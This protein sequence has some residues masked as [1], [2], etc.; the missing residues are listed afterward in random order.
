VVTPERLAAASAGADAGALE[1]PVEELM[2][3]RITVPADAPL[4]EALEA[5][6][7][8]NVRWAPVLDEGRLVGRLGTREVVRTYKSTL[9]QSVRRATSLPPETALFEVTVGGESPLVGRPLAEAG[10]PP[11]TL[12]V[13]VLREG[14]VIFPRATTTM[15][16][17]D[18]LTVLAAADHEHEV[19]SYFAGS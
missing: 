6:A 15:A 8:A 1:L 7:D 18:R 4:D 16:A 17:G 19:R 11:S 10:L 13:T 3:E 2:E 14:E 12:V 5:L 9:R